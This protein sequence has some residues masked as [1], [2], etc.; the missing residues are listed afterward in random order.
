MG[1]K[2]W[3]LAALSLA[4]LALVHI[5]V[6]PLDRLFLFL[7]SERSQCGP[8]DAECIARLSAVRGN[9]SPSVAIVTVGNET[10]NVTIRV[11]T[12]MR[13]GKC[14]TEEV[15]LDDAN[16]GIAP[17]DIT[18][19]NTTCDV[20]LDKLSE[21]G[22][23]ACNGSLLSYISPD[24]TAPSAGGGE[25]GVGGEDGYV[26]TAYCSLDAQ[27]CK[28]TAGEY[29]KT[30]REAQITMDLSIN[31][32]QGGTSYWTIFINID[33]LPVEYTD[34]GKLQPRCSIYHELINAVNLPPEIPPGIIGMNMT[35][36][37]ELDMFPINGVSVSSCEGALV[38]YMQIIYP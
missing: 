30:C 10:N 35:C 5:Y 18:G 11:T 13:D 27:D 22:Q 6:M 17:F 2:W 3:A 8:G 36:E 33:R 7:I 34:T 32:S 28:E 23:K 29:V 26:Y 12:F 14:V 4:A 19:Y 24:S 20:P 9:C 16:S 31:H 15:V 21:F 37:I 25:N 1:R 38:D